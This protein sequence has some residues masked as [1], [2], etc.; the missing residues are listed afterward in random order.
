[1]AFVADRMRDGILLAG[2][3]LLA[4]LYVVNGWQKLTNFSGTV[5]YMAGVG[6]PLPLLSAGIA[7]V[8]ELILAA[9]CAAGFMTRPL[10]LLLSAYTLATAFIGHRYWTM[11]GAAQTDAFEHFLKNVSIAGGF[12][13]LFAA[14]PG[15]WALDAI[16]SRA[17]RSATRAVG[18]DAT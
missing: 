12:L 18:T 2:R 9:V 6:A 10:A 13:L 16:R 5:D 15:A 17:N 1:M 7:V 4:L 3:L 14:G 11:T 8:V